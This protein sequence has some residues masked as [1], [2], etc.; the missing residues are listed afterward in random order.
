VPRAAAA[1]AR[2]LA[3]Y[4]AFA[5]KLDAARLKAARQGAAAYRREIDAEKKSAA[6]DPSIAGLGAAGFSQSCQAR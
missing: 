6:S 4:V 3:A 1:R 2:A 5:G